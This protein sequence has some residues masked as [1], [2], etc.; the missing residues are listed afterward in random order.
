MT[1]TLT[2]ALADLAATHA[3]AA[4]LAHILRGGDVI[5]LRGPLGIGKSEIARALIRARAGAEIEVPSPSFTLIQDYELDGLTIRHIDLYRVRTPEELLE[6]GLEG[7]PGE[8]EA[9]LVEWPERAEGRLAG[10]RLD[11]MLEDG[12]SGRARVA[13][14]TADAAW[15]SRLGAFTD[16]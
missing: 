3:L 6:L 14:L 15:T 8:D 2:L 16:G 7:A 10:A 11:V 12:T 13:H 9:R 5:A 1:S 4:T